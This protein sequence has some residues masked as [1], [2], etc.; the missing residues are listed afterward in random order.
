M[1]RYA[2][3][4][5]PEP[6]RRLVECIWTG[7]TVADA[8]GAP[9]RAGE[10]RILPDGCIDIVLA[11]GRG[12]EEASVVGTMTRAFV[13]PPDEHASWIGVRFRP[14]CAPALLDIPASELTNLSVPLSDVWR[15]AA[16][17]LERLHEDAPL[18]SRASLIAGALAR[19]LA[20]GRAA[21]AREVLAAVDR[22]S[23]SGGNL[24]IG[25]LA[26]ALGVSRQHLARAFAREV[27][28]PPKTFAR[29]V[30][31]RRL[32]DRVRDASRADWSTLALDAGYY[33]QAHLIAEFR[34]LTG[35]TPTRWLAR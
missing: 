26:P 27:G 24:A 7:E 13:V 11:F 29:V 28:V 9:P 6:L 1:H 20:Q 3:H 23:A 17:L 31:L 15:D 22:I 30:R 32:L 34:E 16:P 33:D 2:E 25:S 12:L 19:R 5:P 35:L 21:P 10:R 14:G 18:A 4:A 8:R